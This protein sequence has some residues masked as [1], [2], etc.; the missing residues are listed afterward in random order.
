[1]RSVAKGLP[2]SLEVAAMIAVVLISVG[3][4][5]AYLPAGLITG[6]VLLLLGVVFAA[7]GQS[8]EAPETRD[9]LRRRVAG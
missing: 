2:G 8:A 4:G 1:M 3:A 6:G 7:R 5:L 9:E